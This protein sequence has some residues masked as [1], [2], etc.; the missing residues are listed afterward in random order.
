MW[1]F[2]ED[3]LLY[4]LECAILN[5]YI[6]YLYVCKDMHCDAHHK[7][8]KRADRAFK[9][10]LATAPIGGYSSKS[11]AGRR[12]TIS[13]D[14]LSP[15]LAW[16]QAFSLWQKECGEDAPRKN[17][18]W[19]GIKNENR[20]VSHVWCACVL[21]LSVI[22]YFYKH[23]PKWYGSWNV[24]LLALRR[25]PNYAECSLNWV[26]M[27]FVLNLIFWVHIFSILLPPP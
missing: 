25:E 4:L 2:V 8:K 20:C 7:L 14:R 11:K 16:S 12:S 17:G 15:S 1:S 23:S 21:E 10:E 26:L 5:A 6:I 24:S 19:K 18:H 13:A 3:Y 9:F 22:H 27:C